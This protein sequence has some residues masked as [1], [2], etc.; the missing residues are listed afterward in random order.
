MISYNNTQKYVPQHENLQSLSQI[1]SFD[2][3]SGAH[4]QSTEAFAAGICTILL[5]IVNQRHKTF[6]FSQYCNGTANSVLTKLYKYYFKT[7]LSL[8]IRLIFNELLKD[9]SLDSEEISF[10]NDQGN[11]NPSSS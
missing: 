10:W 9:I 11:Q 3:H 7:G 8:M 1:I 2:N 4:S 6:Q 5:L